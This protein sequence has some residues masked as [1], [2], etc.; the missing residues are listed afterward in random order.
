M[1]GS[2]SAAMNVSGFS[3]G[4]CQ[5][6]R[7][8]RAFLFISVICLLPSFQARSGILS[9]PY[10]CSSTL[11]LETATSSRRLLSTYDGKILSDFLN[12]LQN[13]LYETKCISADWLKEPAIQFYKIQKM[14]F[15]IR[16]KVSG[17]QSVEFITN[18]YLLFLPGNHLSNANNCL[19]LPPPHHKFTFSLSLGAHLLL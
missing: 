15:C 7:K 18:Y 8:N 19:F 3:E 4:N 12:Y 16:T 14:Q 11:G 10:P 9:S 2:Q 13:V 6:P 5:L 17:L 1:D